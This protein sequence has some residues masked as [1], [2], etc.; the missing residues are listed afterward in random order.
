MR[1]I[2]GHNVFI[3]N[4]LLGHFTANFTENII[5]IKVKPQLSNGCQTL[6]DNW[7]T[8]YAEF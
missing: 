6:N 5:F 4:Y 3:I 8:F 1:N 2:A 7:G